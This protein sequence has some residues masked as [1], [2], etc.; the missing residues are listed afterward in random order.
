M[1]KA[2]ELCRSPCAAANDRTNRNVGQCCFGSASRFSPA[3]G[4][5]PHAVPGLTESANPHYHPYLF[6]PYSASAPRSRY[7]DSNFCLKELS[8]SPFVHSTSAGGASS[9]V[10]SW[11][12]PR[13]PAPGF[14]I[15]T[16]S[17]TRYGSTCWRNLPVI[18]WG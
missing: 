11:R 1:R 8:K 13:R 4:R 15:T 17:T 14:I 12:L 18:T 9:T 6:W 3:A 2:A 7:C 10:S 5:A 16:T